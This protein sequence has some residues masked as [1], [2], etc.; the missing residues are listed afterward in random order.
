MII[1]AWMHCVRDHKMAGKLKMQQI[2]VMTG[3]SVSTV[4]RVLAGKSN[5]SPQARSAILRSAQEFGVLDELISGRLLI[6]GVIIFAPDRAFNS[7]D[8]TFYNE[9]IK[10]IVEA[11]APHDI[12]IRYCG[13]EEQQADLKLFLKKASD[14]N[15]NAMIIIGVDDPTIHKL[16]ATLNKPCILI[17]T[18]DR[19]MLLD[20]VSPD[21]RA[22]G[23][24]AARHLYQQGHRRLLCLTSLRR[25]TMVSRLE[26]VKEAARYFHAPF[27]EALN[28]VVTEGFGAVESE[29]ALERW[30]S[31]HSQEQWPTAILCAGVFMAKGAQQVLQRRNLTV[32]Q[33]VSL[34]VTDFSWTLSEPFSPALTAIQVPCRELGI[35]AV[36]LLQNRIT[37][38]HTPVFNLMLQG[39]LLV[40]DSVIRTTR[41][42][43][44]EHA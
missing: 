28:L 16:A 18:T 4:S 40:R 24:S 2:A 13:L 36:H 35:E 19:E 41:S 37:R 29:A 9:V 38:P 3:Y 6:N 31:Q 1:F 30:F 33:D 43:P 32:A 34:M 7:R 12:Y 23:F 20:N 26:G 14:S 15:I 21:H 10:G 22:I 11:I 42:I 39:R 27:D 44:R 8:D 25:D 5:T 17:N